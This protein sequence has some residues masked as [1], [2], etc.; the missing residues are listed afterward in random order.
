[1]ARIDEVP[2]NIADRVTYVFEVTC[3]GTDFRSHPDPEHNQ[4]EF[5][6]QAVRGALAGAERLRGRWTTVS[7]TRVENK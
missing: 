2:A 6:A 5:L 7:F 4:I 1:M 3:E